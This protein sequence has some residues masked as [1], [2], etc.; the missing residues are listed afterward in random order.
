MLAKQRI[1]EIEQEEEGKEL[2]L[3]NRTLARAEDLD[4]KGQ[5]LKARNLWKSIMT[6]YVDN[7]EFTHQVEYARSRYN[8]EDVEVIDF[9]NA[10]PSSSKSTNNSNTSFES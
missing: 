5:L 3:I 10:T 9:S 2:A 7:E 4:C 8:N 1:T 6:L